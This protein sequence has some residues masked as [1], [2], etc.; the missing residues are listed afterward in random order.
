MASTNSYKWLDEDTL[1]TNVAR[2]F[3][4]FC[5]E[6]IQELEKLGILE[7]E[8]YEEAVKRIIE[9]FESKGEVSKA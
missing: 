3:A 4:E 1:S 2:R 5:K 9:E 6:D 8:I 7:P